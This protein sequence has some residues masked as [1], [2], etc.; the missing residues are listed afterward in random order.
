M[1]PDNLIRKNESLLSNFTL[2]KIFKM[3]LLEHFICTLKQVYFFEISTKTDMV[4]LTVRWFLSQHKCDKTYIYTYTCEDNPAYRQSFELSL[5]LESVETE[6]PDRFV[7]RNEI[8]HRDV[9]KRS[10]SPNPNPVE[11]AMWYAWKYDTFSVCT[12]NG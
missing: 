4:V 3:R 1:I 9:T 12:F 5:F 11:C 2:F 7:S 6:N 8:A 10:W